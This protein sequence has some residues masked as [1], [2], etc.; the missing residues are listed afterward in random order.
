MKIK[1]L[2][3]ALAI[4]ISLFLKAQVPGTISYQSVLTDGE[5]V[6]LVSKQVAIKIGVKGYS[7]RGEDLGYD[8]Y[9]RHGTT[10]SS[11]GV[12]TIFIGAGEVLLGDFSK[13]DW[14]S[15]GRKLSFEIDIA[16]NG[17]YT[18]S[19]TSTI[20]SVPYALRAAV[21]DSLAFGEQDPLFTAS[22][23]YDITALDI[24]K[25]NTSVVVEGN[26]STVLPVGGINGQI[27]STDGNGVYRWID[28]LDD[29]TATEVAFTA[30]ENIAATSVQAALAELDN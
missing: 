22:P 30:T 24:V 17:N 11:N 15:E 9:E 21:S 5:G 27:L 8:Y 14:S 10:T 20:S 26:T 6:V 29:Q 3:A 16:G 28:I 19:G 2:M 12:M 13:I 23:A 1:I 7:A 4:T 18:I 25:W